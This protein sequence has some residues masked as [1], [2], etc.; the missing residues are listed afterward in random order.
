MWC[1]PRLTL[2]EIGFS[3]PIISRSNVLFPHPLGPALHGKGRRHVKT[4]LTS[5]LP[6]VKAALTTLIEDVRTDVNLHNADTVPAHDIRCLSIL[7]AC[8]RL[9]EGASFCEDF[10]ETCI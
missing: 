3:R 9:F 8:C 1:W 5:G 4:A 6:H 10:L 7:R 2:P